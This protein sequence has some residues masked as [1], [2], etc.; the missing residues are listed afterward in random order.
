MKHYIVC[1]RILTIK[2]KITELRAHNF[3][4]NVCA[5]EEMFRDTNITIRLSL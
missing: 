2:K 4:K 3:T 5:H 1:G